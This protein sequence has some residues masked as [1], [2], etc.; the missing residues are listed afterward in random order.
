MSSNYTKCVII[1]DLILAILLALYYLQTF[2]FPADQNTCF[3]FCMINLYGFVMTSILNVFIIV[4]IILNSVNL[5]K[6][7]KINNNS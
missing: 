4:N 7:S 5:C 2:I 1:T 6:L 3:P